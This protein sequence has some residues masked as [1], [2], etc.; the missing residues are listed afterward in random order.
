MK[1]TDVMM[2]V[3]NIGMEKKLRNYGEAVDIEFN[4]DRVPLGNTE[5]VHN[6]AMAKTKKGIIYMMAELVFIADDKLNMLEPNAS[7]GKTTN[8]IVDYI[9]VESNGDLTLDSEGVRNVINVGMQF[10]VRSFLDNY[11]LEMYRNIVLGD[12]EKPTNIIKQRRNE[13]CHCGSGRKYKGCCGNDTKKESG[14]SNKYYG[15]VNFARRS[16]TI[17]DYLNHLDLIKKVWIRYKQIYVEGVAK[18][19]GL[20]SF[21]DINR[22]IDIV[23]SEFEISSDADIAIEGWFDGMAGI[24]NTKQHNSKQLFK[25]LDDELQNLDSLR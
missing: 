7:E 17:E 18:K 3:S 14:C 12:L 21:D 15:N 2:E 10:D 13:R 20:V 5:V 8:D 19:G 4:Q 24:M 9:K 11:D 22:Y 25:L 23:K 1:I 16:A 6:L